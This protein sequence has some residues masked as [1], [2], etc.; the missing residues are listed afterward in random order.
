MHTIYNSLEMKI[1]KLKSASVGLSWELILYCL[2][3]TNEK[4]TVSNQLNHQ[5]LCFTLLSDST[6]KLLLRLLLRTAAR[7]E[8]HVAPK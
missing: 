7:L 8:K 3:A 4:A 6:T 1:R 5:A 2:M